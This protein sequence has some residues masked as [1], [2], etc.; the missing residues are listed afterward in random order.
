MEPEGLDGFIIHQ[1]RQQKVSALCLC[2]SESQEAA[3]SPLPQHFASAKSN[4]TL[5]KLMPDCFVPSFVFTLYF[6]LCVCV[7]FLPKCS[8]G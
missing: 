3:S 2:M 1:W 5:A 4:E 8:H 6:F 7:F